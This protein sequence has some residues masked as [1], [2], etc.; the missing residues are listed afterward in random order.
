MKSSPGAYTAFGKKVK[1]EMVKRGLTSK[2]LAKTM[3]YTESTLCDV[4][5]GRNRCERRMRELAEALGLDDG[6]QMST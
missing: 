1:I 5:K 2:E 3:G 6:E 4:L